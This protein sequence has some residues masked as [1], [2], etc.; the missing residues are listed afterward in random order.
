[1]R[2]DSEPTIDRRRLLVLL[3]GA[4]VAGV[5]HATPAGADGDVW[6][7]APGVLAA[8]AA[9]P[10]R[11]DPPG[12]TCRGGLTPAAVALRTA[13][14][15]ATGITDIGGYACRANTASPSRL[16]V[17]AVGR[18]LD[19]MVRGDRG[20]RLA[21]ALVRDA[22]SLGVQLVIWRRR[23]WRSGSGG[24]RTYGGPNPH[25]DHI[26]VEVF[27]SAPDAVAPDGLS[28]GPVVVTPRLTR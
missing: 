2:H 26:H 11:Y 8:A 5:A 16:S 6:R 22:A 9:T 24:V 3:C 17:H 14:T 4:A 7:P 25:T 18:A 27:A 12:A 28:L 20:D 21:D 1:M 15:R 10:A 23:I 19:V 13:I